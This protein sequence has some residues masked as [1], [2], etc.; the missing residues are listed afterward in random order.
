M[1]SVYAAIDKVDHKHTVM[2]VME[3][4]KR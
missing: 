3:G 1:Q 4:I 2:Q